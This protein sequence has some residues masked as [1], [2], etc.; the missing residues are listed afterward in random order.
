[1]KVFFSASILGR[2]SFEENY[3]AIVDDLK[4]RGYKVQSDHV[5]GVDKKK[6]S[7]VS[8]KYRIDYYRKLVKWISESDLIVAEVTQPSISIGHE[9]SL[10]LEKGKNVIALSSTTRGPAIFLAMKSDKLQMLKYN[11]EDLHFVLDKAIKR[12]RSNTDIRFNFFISPQ[13]NDYLDWISKE[14]RI[15]RAVYLRDLL[16]K[17]M[18]KSKE[19]QEEKSEN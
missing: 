8:D 5:L 4:D 2:D 3:K 10:A 17:E 6:L 7:D 13:I 1:M 18:A 16:E 11:L 19:Y 15:P 9:V 14:K 12:A